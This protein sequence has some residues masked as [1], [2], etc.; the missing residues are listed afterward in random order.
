MAADERRKDTRVGLSIPVRVQG[1]E[2][3]GRHW[4]EMTSSKDTSAGGCSLPLHHFVDIGHV[5]QLTLPLPK[6]FRRYALNDATYRTYSLVR[7]VAAGNPGRVGVM[8]MGKNAPRDF[9][10]NPGGRYLLPGDPPPKPRDRRRGGRLDVFLNLKVKR[11]DADGAVV[12]EEATVSENF[13]VGG[14]RVLTSLPVVKHE[15]VL[16]ADL[17]GAFEVKAEV[18]NVFVGPDHVPRLNLRFL[19]PEASVQIGRAAGIAETHLS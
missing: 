15:V 3:D 11:L 10:K 1:W 18:R 14:L 16:V 5:L 19:D 6:P 9:L 7:T 4:E 17:A 13:S 8:F 2:A 12:Q